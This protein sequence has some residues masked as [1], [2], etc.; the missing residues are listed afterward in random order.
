MGAFGVAIMARDSKKENVF[1]FEIDNY[2]L[3]T[4][5]NNCSGCA[6]NCEIIEIYKNDQLIDRW[7]NRC[8]QVKILK[9]V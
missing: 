6:N 7:G 8:E 4:R 3:E 9:N 5:L 2:K 1:D